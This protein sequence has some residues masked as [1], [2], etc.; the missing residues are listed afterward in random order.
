[1]PLKKS[2]ADIFLYAPSIIQIKL[3]IVWL[4][5]YYRN[6]AQLLFRPQKP[7]HTNGGTMVLRKAFE[8]QWKGGQEN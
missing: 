5:K 4:F 6:N 2:D 3:L 7:G 1:M 8:N